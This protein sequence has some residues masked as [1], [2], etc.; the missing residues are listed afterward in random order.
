MSLSH[1]LHHWLWAIRSRSPIQ[2]DAKAGWKIGYCNYTAESSC[3]PLLLC[4]VSLAQSQK[5]TRS[6][7]GEA[8]TTPRDKT[9]LVFSV[10]LLYWEETNSRRA[11]NNLRLA[12]SSQLT[13]PYPIVELDRMRSIE[14]HEIDFHHSVTQ[15]PYIFVRWTVNWFIQQPLV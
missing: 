4:S 14:P 11:Y 6:N 15:S 13:S 1:C 10:T 5:T 7:S 3:R 9:R 2:C 8:A 12:Y